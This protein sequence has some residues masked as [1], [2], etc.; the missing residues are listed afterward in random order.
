MGFGAALVL[1]AAGLSR[2]AALR[3][4]IRG[5]LPRRRLE[6]APCPA[7]DCCPSKLEPIPSDTPGLTGYCEGDGECGTSKKLDNCACAG[8]GKNGAPSPNR[9]PAARRSRC[10]PVK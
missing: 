7:D 1:A 9:L 6:A 8:C 2:A 10:F 5:G 3:P 4:R